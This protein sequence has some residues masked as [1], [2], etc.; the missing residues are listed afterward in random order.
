MTECR[1]KILVVDDDEIHLA[2]VEA[3]LKTEYEII[4]A[5]S[6]KEALELFLHGP[7]P[8]LIF[9]DIMMPNMDGWETFNRLKAISLLRNVPIIFLSSVSETDEVE[10]AYKMGAAGF[11]RKPYDKDDLLAK[12]KKVLN[13]NE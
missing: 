11:I 4:T 1:P 9:L 2:M 13:A 8:N 10:R 3:I 7:A 12:I 5:K 6:G